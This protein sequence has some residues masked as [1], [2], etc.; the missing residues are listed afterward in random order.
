MRSW[1]PKCVFPIK[2][3]VNYPYMYIT[4]HLYHYAIS[5]FSVTVYFISYKDFNPM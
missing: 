3:N 1:I 5:W 4:V 2:F